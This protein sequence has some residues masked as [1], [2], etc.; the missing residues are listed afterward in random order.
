MSWFKQTFG[1]DFVDFAIQF[2]LTGLA[3]GFADTA[4]RPGGNS[5]PLLFGVAGSS[6]LL[7]A[8]RRHLALKR[9]ATEPAGLT[10][11]QMAATRIEELEER[12]AHLEAGEARMAELEER[13]D[14]AERLLAQTTRENLALPGE[15]PR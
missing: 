6:I 10:T 8:V 2:V 14:F 3:M 7:F 12:L 13:L 4:V 1:I 9:A 11:G 5:E 15:P